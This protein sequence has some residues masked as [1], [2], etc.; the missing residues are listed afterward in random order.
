MRKQLNEENMANQ[1]LMGGLNVATNT[2]EINFEDGTVQTTAAVSQPAPA[3]LVAT[4]TL[5]AAQLL[6]LSSTPVQ[7]IP[8][9]GVGNYLFPQYYTMSYHFGGTAYTSPAHTNDC[10]FTLGNP[11]ATISNEVMV[12]AW[13]AV[14]SGIIEATQSV[15]FFGICGEGLIPATVANNAP[16]MFSAPNALTLGNGVLVITVHYSV[17]PV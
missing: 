4:V 3:I 14:T 12:Y 8:A 1:H 9:P 15:V 16:L 10:Y 17:L 2:S 11:P 13:A 6:A 5:T 7:V